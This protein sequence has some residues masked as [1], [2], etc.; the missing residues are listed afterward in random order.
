MIIRTSFK[1]AFSFWP[2]IGIPS[3]LKTDSEHYKTILDHEVIH[4]NRQGWRSLWW[5]LKYFGF[6]IF[7]RSKWSKNFRFQEE[8]V[9]YTAEIKSRQKFCLQIDL[10]WYKETLHKQ[11][12]GMCTYDE[13]EEFIDNIKW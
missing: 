7:I 2:I 6:F 4:Y 3:S 11:Y 8:K 1:R 5:I 10:D 13:A 9:A 12:W